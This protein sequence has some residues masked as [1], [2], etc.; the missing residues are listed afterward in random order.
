MKKLFL[1]LTLMGMVVSSCR[2]LIDVEESI[3]VPLTETIIEYTESTSRVL[4]ATS[5]MLVI[6]IVANLNVS[7]TKFIHVEHDAFADIKI[8]KA[9]IENIEKY[10]RTA[11]GRAI[12]ACDAD[13]LISPI[14]EVTTKDG[15]LVITVSGYPAKYNSFRNATEKDIKLVKEANDTN[16]GDNKP[17]KDMLNIQVDK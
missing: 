13:V 2:P 14:I 9:T 3:Q 10:K 6:P 4:D 7:N 11:L 1:V 12:R 5:N 8:T 15:R 16:I 17:S